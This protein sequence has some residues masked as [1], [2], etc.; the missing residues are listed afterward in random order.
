MKTYKIGT[1]E[2]NRKI[3]AL[4]IEKIENYGKSQLKSSNSVCQSGS[5]ANAIRSTFQNEKEKKLL[6]SIRISFYTRVQSKC[7]CCVCVTKCEYKVAATGRQRNQN[8]EA[9]KFSEVSKT[10][11]Q[12]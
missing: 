12:L 1:V 11:I 5:Y 4:K 10:F 2:D 7:C 9:I 6:R 3:E 8:L